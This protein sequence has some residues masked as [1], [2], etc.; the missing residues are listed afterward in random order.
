[1]TD[2]ALNKKQLHHNYHLEVILKTKYTKLSIITN[3]I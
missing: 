1:M 2:G 3:P